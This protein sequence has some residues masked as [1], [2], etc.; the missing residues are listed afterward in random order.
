MFS[1]G[2]LGQI[3]HL[4]SWTI[5]LPFFFFN[6]N[7]KVPVS[8]WKQDFEILYQ[9]ARAKNIPV[10]GVVSNREQARTQFVGTSFSGLPLFTCDYTAI[11][12]AARTSPTIYLLQKGTVME[13]VSHKN[14]ELVIDKVEAIPSQQPV[15]VEQTQSTKANDSSVNQTGTNQLP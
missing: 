3:Q 11:R 12:T 7:F 1:L 9:A 15:P 6:D 10:Y 14:I 2:Q 5:P 4:L 13:K 8:E